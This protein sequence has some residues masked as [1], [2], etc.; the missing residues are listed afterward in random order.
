[1]LRHD[2]RWREEDNQNWVRD[3]IF[4]SWHASRAG[5]DRI[6]QQWSRT[7]WRCLKNMS[8]FSCIGPHIFSSWK[9]NHL[10]WSL[11]SKFAFQ[12]QSSGLFSSPPIKVKQ[13]DSKLKLPGEKS[14]FGLLGM[15]WYLKQEVTKAN[16]KAY[17]SSY[18]FIQPRNR[19]N[20]RDESWSLF[21]S[22]FDLNVFHFLPFWN[23]LDIFW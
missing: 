9:Q 7:V 18:L 2:G 12:E 20:L 15:A 1:M 21:V 17:G 22:H 3:I 8:S 4:I 19:I 16:Y 11:Q 14:L 6:L 10:K 13:K 23:V 5:V